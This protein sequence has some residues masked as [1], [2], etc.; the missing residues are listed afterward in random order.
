M[1][2]SEGRGGRITTSGAAPASGAPAAPV[3]PPPK[4]APA[5]GADMA[6]DSANGSRGADAAFLA[7]LRSQA[8]AGVAGGAA[9]GSAGEA[10]MRFPLAAVDVAKVG[11]YCMFGGGEGAGSGLGQ[12]AM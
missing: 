1:V 12:S 5:P 9:A 10:L 8:G 2:M 4:G 6:F 3:G 7:L 11:V